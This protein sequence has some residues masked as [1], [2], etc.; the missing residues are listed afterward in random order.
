IRRDRRR[1]RLR[2]LYALRCRRHRARLAHE[3]LAFPGRAIGYPGYRRAQPHL[4]RPRARV[5][6][7]AAR[8]RGNAL[9]FGW[10]HSARF[11]KPATAMHSAPAAKAAAHQTIAVV[12]TERGVNGV[13]MT[14]AMMGGSR[15]CSAS[16]H[17]TSVGLTRLITVPT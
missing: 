6:G 3:V 8:P 17:N 1:Q 5:V 15:T 10:P 4:H 9:R 13:L 16:R 12:G 2:G 11:W 14:C 7:G